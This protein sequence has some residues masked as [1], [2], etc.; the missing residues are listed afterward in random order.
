MWMQCVM[1]LN[2]RSSEMSHISAKVFFCFCRTQFRA[3]TTADKCFDSFSV[4]EARVKP[5]QALTPYVSF[6]KMTALKTLC[7][8]SRFRPCARNVFNAN[9]D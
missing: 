6:A 4:A 7:R 2:S 8:H 3:F 9:T 5:T 1:L